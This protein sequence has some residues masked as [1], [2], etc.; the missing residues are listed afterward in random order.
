V[1]WHRGRNSRANCRSPGSP[2]TQGVQYPRQFLVSG[3]IDELA[4]AAQLAADAGGVYLTVMPVE[5]GVAIEADRQVLAAVR[6][7][8]RT[9]LG[10]GVFTVDLPRIPVCALAVGL[11]PFDGELP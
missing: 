3:L 9:G 4:P 1:A 2:L 10:L 7:A 5:D 8:N 6:G 11:S